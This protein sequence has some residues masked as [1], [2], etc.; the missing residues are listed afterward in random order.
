M[1]IGFRRSTSARL[2]FKGI[3]FWFFPNNHSHP[4][5]FSSF[6]DSFSS[7]TKQKYSSHQ[8]HL[9]GFSSPS[10][11]MFSTSR[12]LSLLLISSISLVESH[13]A[14][15]LLHEGC[16]PIARDNKHNH[17]SHKRQITAVGSGEGQIDGPTA[18]ASAAGYSC[19]PSKC[20]LP[21][22]HCAST[23]PPGGLDPK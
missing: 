11:K 5:S 20:Q 13:G 12:F 14:G 19:D 16:R 9:R 15:N 17:N 21:N 10:F 3:E 18:G 2:R 1:C 7:K 8:S 6:F 23:D 22:C 4:F